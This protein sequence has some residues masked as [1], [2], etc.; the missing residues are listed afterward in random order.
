MSDPGFQLLY[1]EGPCLVV[2]K[3]AGV[4]TQAPPQF[5]SLETRIKTFLKERE[6]KTG[7]IYLG[8]PHRLDRPVS[9]AMVFAR[10]VRAAQRLSKQFER[11][12]VQK[13]YWALVEGI[14]D[15]PEGTWRDTLWK[16]HGQPLSQVV[17]S[18]HPQ[19][20]PAVLH[21]RT[22]GA[23]PHGSWL[24]IELETGRTHQVRVQAASRG[25]AILGDAQY[26]SQVAFGPVC[27]EPRQRAIAL[28]GRRLSFAHPMTRAPVSIEAPLPTAWPDLGIGPYRVTQ[29]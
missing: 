19:G 28:H 9:G 6:G 3:P 25:H 10:H 26:G 22:L 24:E 21:Y 2:L 17:D 12:E 11:R 20:Q 5:E 23:G 29:P 4:Q 7:N 27:E 15:P 18:S 13:I 16:V 14:V 1:E 8:V